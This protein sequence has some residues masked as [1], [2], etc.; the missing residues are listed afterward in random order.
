M[1][2]A[3]NSSKTSSAQPSL[4]ANLFFSSEKAPSKADVSQRSPRKVMLDAINEQIKIVEAEIQGETYT[5]SRIKVSKSEDGTRVNREVRVMP[6]RMFWQA[7][8]GRWLVG[9][10]VSL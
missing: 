2:P 4:L 8:D 6:R 3:R 1:T 9:L 7:D 10:G 5:V